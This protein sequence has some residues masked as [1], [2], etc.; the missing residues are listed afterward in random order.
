MSEYKKI[1]LES[2]EKKAFITEVVW[3]A[4]GIVCLAGMLAAVH[5]GATQN[6]DDAWMNWFYGIRRPGLTTLLTAITYLGCW[7]AIVIVCLLFLMYK[8]Y[9][10]TF[11]IPLSLGA[12][13][14]VSINKGLK[15]LMMRPRP[16]SSMWL[17][18][19]GGYSCPSG[20]ASVAFAVYL[21]LALLII[22]YMQPSATRKLCTIAIVTIAV[23][24]GLSRVYLGVH[25]IS[26]V[27]AGQFEGLAIAM[28]VMI[29]YGWF[30]KKKN[31]KMARRVVPD[32]DSVNL[33][34]IEAGKLKIHK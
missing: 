34:K 30:V 19:E 14:Q 22:K 27:I 16:D 8:Q 7:Q 13:L 31:W 23:A 4:V 9:I 32:P 6:T 3:L 11:G 18:H 26:D 33:K 29:G 2:I 25:Y 17:V 12:L 5:S 24:I 15:L 28:I 20:H 21:L 1:T 10:Y